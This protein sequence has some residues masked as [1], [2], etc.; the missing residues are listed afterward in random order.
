MKTYVLDILNRIRRKSEELDAKTILTNKAWKIFN[1]DEKC[2][3]F[4]LEK[5][6]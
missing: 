6:K 5:C 3:V 4:Y 2:P 1:D